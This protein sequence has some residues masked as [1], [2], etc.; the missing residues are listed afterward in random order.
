[1]TRAESI[2]RKDRV[3]VIRELISDATA[4]TPRTV[5]DGL[6][7]QGAIRFLQRK[8]S[9]ASSEVITGD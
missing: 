5:E 8:L 1:M 3:Q 4:Q 9:E 7:Q 2:G 6:E